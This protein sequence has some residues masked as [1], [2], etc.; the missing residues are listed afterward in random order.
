MSLKFTAMRALETRA[1][2]GEVSSTMFCA[3]SGL[4]FMCRCGFSH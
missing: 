2:L 1:T 3:V 4:E